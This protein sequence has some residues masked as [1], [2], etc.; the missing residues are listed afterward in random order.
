MVHLRP[1]HPRRTQR[2]R[3]LLLRHPS[4]P[5]THG[6]FW[7]LRQRPNRAVGLGHP[8]RPS[9]VHVG[10]VGAQPR[11]PHI[12]GRWVDRL[13]HHGP[14]R[15][16]VLG[17]QQHASQR[18]TGRELLHRRVG[19]RIARHL[20]VDC[21]R[22]PVRLERRDVRVGSQRLGRLPLLRGQLLA[23]LVPSRKDARVRRTG[24]TCRARRIGLG[25]PWRLVSRG[26]SKILPL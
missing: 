8:Q 18:N 11:V 25:N 19:S 9:A 4:Q 14:E 21:A 15:E 1:T 13:H 16:G 20:G 5:A 26:A 23:T 7:V 22:R 12:P 17:I 10:R 24:V 2:R 6:A 3:A